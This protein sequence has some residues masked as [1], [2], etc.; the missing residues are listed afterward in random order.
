MLYHRNCT[1]YRK[2]EYMLEISITNYYQYINDQKNMD[3]DL[4]FFDLASHCAGAD[5]R[6]MK[7]YF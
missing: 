7:R 6:S 1:G 5:V 2:L 3:M 4:K